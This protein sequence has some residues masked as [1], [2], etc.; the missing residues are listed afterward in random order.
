MSGSY[1]KL[2]H[3]TCVILSLLHP[4]AFHYRTMGF[5]LADMFWEREASAHAG[6]QC[7]YIIC[8]FVYKNTSPFTSSAE[9]LMSIPCSH[10]KPLGKKLSKENGLTMGKTPGWED[11]KERKSAQHL[12]PPKFIPSKQGGQTQ[13]TWSWQLP[14]F[15]G[16]DEIS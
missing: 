10:P 14:V 16:K 4:Q 2:W 6:R 13:I 9:T 15:S 11:T 7:P 5:H 1:L 3:S 12:L 8:F